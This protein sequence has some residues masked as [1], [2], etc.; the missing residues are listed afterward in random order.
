MG[1]EWRTGDFSTK[2]GVVFFLLLVLASVAVVNGTPF[3]VPGRTLAS[4]HKQMRYQSFSSIQAQQVLTES[5]SFTFRVGSQNQL[6]SIPL[7]PHFGLYW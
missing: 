3:D 2:L 6:L 7:R 4:Q 5:G 1:Y